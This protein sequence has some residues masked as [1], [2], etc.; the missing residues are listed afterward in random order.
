MFLPFS[1]KYFFGKSIKDKRGGDNNIHSWDIEVKGGVSKQQAEILNQL[2]KQRRKKQWALEIGIDWMDGM[3]L[4]LEQ[5]NTFVSL[6][7]IELGILL[8]DLTKKGYL[9]F[10][11]PKKLVKI[12]TE[13]GIATS[14]E[15]DETKPKGYNIVTGKLSFEINKILDPKDIAPTLVATDV[16]RLAVPDGNGLRRLT[17]REGLRLFGY[18]EW[19]EIPTKEQDAF[20]LLGNTVAVPVVEFVASKIA[21]NFIRET[22][23]LDSIH[24]KLHQVH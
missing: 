6:P 3:T 22:K 19:Y 14:R 4:T 17:L 2:F 20:D 16:S 11:H 15:Y 7:K 9:K 1:S 21:T 12:Y 10:E 8:D 5:I 24:S 23:D 13:N 18:P